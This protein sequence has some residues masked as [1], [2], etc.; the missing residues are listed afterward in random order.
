MFSYIKSSVTKNYNFKPIIKVINRIFMEKYQPPELGRWGLV[1]DERVTRKI[2]W[3][4][5]DHCGPCGSLKLDRYNNSKLD[6]CNDKKL[7]K[8]TNSKTK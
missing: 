4:N 6:S 7:E 8:Y 5:E 3:S 1:Y 2:D